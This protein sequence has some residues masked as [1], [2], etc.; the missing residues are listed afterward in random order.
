MTSTA[1]SQTRSV[2]PGEVSDLQ[3]GLHTSPD[4]CGDLALIAQQC[5]QCGTRCFPRRMRCVNCFSE[6]FESVQ[7]GRIGKVDACTVV[8][9]APP[10]YNG[11]MPYVLAMVLVEDD[12]VTL[13]HLV[14][15]DV[16][17]WHRGDAVASC[18]LILPV[19]PDRQ[20][21]RTFAFRPVEQRDLNT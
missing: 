6:D 19:G 1:D 7:L 4:A 11:H 14:G 12:I 5:T 17:D 18:E 2:A 16:Q 10:G 13:C 3:P 21:K 8:R 15:K 9:Q 20:L